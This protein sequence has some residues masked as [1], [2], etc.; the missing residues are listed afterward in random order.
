MVNFLTIMNVNEFM[1][2]KLIHRYQNQVEE[3]HQKTTQNKVCDLGRLWFIHSQ[4]KMFKTN[5]NYLQIHCT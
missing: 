5:E 1:L 3:S 4:I 2:H